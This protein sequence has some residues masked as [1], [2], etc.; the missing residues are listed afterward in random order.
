VRD[1]HRRKACDYS[2]TV[3][4]FPFVLLLTLI[5]PAA[6]AP[7][8][9]AGG[10]RTSIFYYPWYGT[11]SRDGAYEHWDKNGHVPP[12]DVAANFYPR[13]GVYS[14]ADPAVVRAQ[15]REIAQIGVT[16]VISS[17]WGWGSPEDR[18]LVKVLPTA[19]LYRLS[20][21][22]QVE[23][24]EKWART[25]ETLARD[26]GHLRELGV[27]RVYVYRPFDGLID[28]AGWSRLTREATGM[29]LIAET[30]DPARAAAAGFVGVYTYDV[31]TMRATSFRGLCRRAHAAGLECV[32]S[33]GPGF[34]AR[35]ATGES[36]VR[37]RRNG[38]TYDAMWKAAIGAGADGLAITS[39]NEWHEGTQ[40]EAARSFPGGYAS[41]DGAWGLRGR[42]AEAAYLQRT[43]YWTG[44]YRAAARD[45][46]VP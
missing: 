3:R 14:S 7:A 44:V 28:D 32:P 18:L 26:L 1:L 40:I 41:Y 46:A 2:A 13:R 33:V 20:V 4:L 5:A 36:R 22:V 19:K 31:L 24:Y 17:W 8:P 35:R 12:R 30:Q 43:R 45:V 9:T 29:Q 6:G 39:Y 23:P 42:R 16:E 27:K 34:D 21:A 37:T 10:G 38:A 11:P 15:I 25:E